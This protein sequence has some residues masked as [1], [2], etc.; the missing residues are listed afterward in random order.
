MDTAPEIPPAKNLRMVFLN[1]YSKG[2]QVCYI[3]NTL[4]LFELVL[5]KKTSKLTIA[6][7]V[8]L[9]LSTFFVTFQSSNVAIDSTHKRTTGFLIYPGTNKA[10]MPTKKE[11]WL[12]CLIVNDSL[13]IIVNTLPWDAAA[14]F[15]SIEGDKDHVYQNLFRDHKE[16]EGVFTNWDPF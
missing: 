3:R 12:R 14:S 11:V 8:L 5:S 9:N 13:W 10:P 16:V 7:P 4:R 15:K 2:F 1:G 6:F